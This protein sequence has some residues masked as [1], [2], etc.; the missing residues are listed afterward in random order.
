[1]V[2]SPPANNPLTE[3]NRQLRRAH[4]SSE[5]ISCRIHQLRGAN[6]GRRSI[7]GGRPNSGEAAVIAG[8]SL[9]VSPP[10]ANNPLTEG[11]RQLRR[12][13]C[14]SEDSP[15]RIHQ[16]RRANAGRRRVCGGRRNSCEAAVIGGN[17]LLVSSPPAT[18]PLTE[19]NRQLR[20]A[21]CSTEDSPRR[22]HQLR[23]ANVGR[24]SLHGRRRNSCEAAVIGGN[25]L[26]VSPPPAN[27]PL[28]EGSRQLRRAHCSSEVIPRRIHQLRGANVGRR[29]VRGGRPNSCEAAVV[30]G[31]NLL[32]SPPPATIP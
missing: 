21:H 8:N 7:R 4:C 14:S 32:V 6:A 29:S 11:N 13:H 20:R 27:T 24:R 23:G 15:C 22:L 3:G 28:T 2:S 19:G 31:N 25:N 10:P 9:L 1:M 18:N 16:L 26:L 12:A 5:V 17:N 30:G